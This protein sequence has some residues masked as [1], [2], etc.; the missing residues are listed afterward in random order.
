MSNI[1]STL[2]FQDCDFS[3]VLTR[4]IELIKGSENCN[5][6]WWRFLRTVPEPTLAFFLMLQSRSGR[7]FWRSDSFGKVPFLTVT[8]HIWLGLCRI[9][10]LKE[11]AL[12][13]W[14][15]HC[16]CSCFQVRDLN[17]L[18]D[19]ERIPSYEESVVTLGSYH[20][21]I[22]NWMMLLGLMIAHLLSIYSYW[23]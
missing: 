4:L 9:I 22:F 20:T 16:L 23:Y 7:R 18:R 15:T 1:T 14:V 2:I 17:L 13:Q 21:L 3:F 8:A 12:Y 10:L 11:T 6:G 19:N 5:V